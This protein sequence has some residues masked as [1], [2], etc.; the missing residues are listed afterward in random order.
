MGCASLPVNAP[1]SSNLPH[2]CLPPTPERDRLQCSKLVMEEE[3]GSHL[4]KQDT[5]EVYPAPKSGLG[6]KK[7]LLSLAIVWATLSH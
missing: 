7:V 2:L 6:P 3:G 4:G 1:A 5:Q